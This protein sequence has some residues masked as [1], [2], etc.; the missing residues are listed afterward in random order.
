MRHYIPILY[1]EKL[2]RRD[3]YLPNVTLVKLTRAGTG[4]GLTPKTLLP[5]TVHHRLP[6]G[7]PADAH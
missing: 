7:V 2:S 5:I 3:S 1:M 4:A 6:T